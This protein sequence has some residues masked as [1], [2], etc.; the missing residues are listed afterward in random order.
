[1]QTVR[2]NLNS[3]DE[4]VALQLALRQAH[5]ELGKYREAHNNSLS[6]REVRD[7]HG[8]S[9]ENPRGKVRTRC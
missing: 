2:Q 3:G 8:V 4:I 9:T 7:F 1:M 6:D 5:F